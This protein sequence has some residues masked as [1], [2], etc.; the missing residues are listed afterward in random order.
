[1]SWNKL[2]GVAST[3][4]GACLRAEPA[5]LGQPC[6]TVLPIAYTSIERANCPTDRVAI[7][8]RRLKPIPPR[9]RLLLAAKRPSHLSKSRFGQT[10]VALLVGQLYSIRIGQSYVDLT[11]RSKSSPLHFG[12]INNN[13]GS[14]DENSREQEVKSRPFHGCSR[15]P[16]VLTKLALD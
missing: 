15:H 14:L 6:I 2:H 8:L 12:L 4:D 11:L 16:V 13:S 10:L 9:I 5:P 1:M 7:M 3:L